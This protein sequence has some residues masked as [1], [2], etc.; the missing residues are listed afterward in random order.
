M[1]FLQQI[2]MWVLNPIYRQTSKISSENRDKIVFLMMFL[3]YGS[4]LVWYSINM[5]DIY[6]SHTPRMLL[7]CVILFI[8]ILFIS[9]KPLV[10]IKWNN[11]VA[12]SWII[13]R[14]CNTYNGF[15]RQTECRV[16]V[17][18]SGYGIRISLSV[19]CDFESEGI[20]KIY[21]HHLQGNSALFAYILH[22]GIICGFYKR[23]CV[24][25]MGIKI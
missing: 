11:W 16:L 21:Y 6:I 25:R 14:Y 5:F 4:I 15:C 19:F 12:A 3:V 9:D 20:F 13:C 22:F 7:E 23:Y 24:G 17:Y 10:K 18:W 8:A 1:G 2:Y